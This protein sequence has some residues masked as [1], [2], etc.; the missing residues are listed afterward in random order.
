MKL[1]FKLMISSVLLSSCTINSNFML[2]TKNNY[3]FDEID[4]AVNPEYKI[5]TNDVIDFRLYTNDGFQVIDM[6][7]SG[8]SSTQMNMNNV[9]NVI[10]YNIRQDS[11]VELPIIG[12][13]NLVGK[14]IR[15]AEV[16]LED[17]FSK[18]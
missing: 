6:F 17:L 15:A 3:V 8:K 5:S 12:D 11:L 16:F 9:R 1:L 14:T 7:S 2:K 4:Y 18:Y 13:V 10:Q